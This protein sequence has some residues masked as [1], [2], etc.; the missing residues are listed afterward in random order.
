[1]VPSYQGPSSY[2]LFVKYNNYAGATAGDGNGI[3]KI[4]L[5]DPTAVASRLQY[6]A[7]ALPLIRAELGERTAM[8]GF[9]GAPWTLANFML[10][11][12]SAREFTKAK[13][14]FYS[15]QKLFGLLFEKLT[16]AVTASLQLQIDAGVDA[17]QIFDSLGGNLA[18]NIYEEASAKWIRQIISNLKGKVPVIV[19]GRGVHGSWDSLLRTGAQVLS[20]D[21]TLALGEVRGRLPENVA[22]QGNLDPVVLT[23]TPAIAAAEA[24]MILESMRGTNGHIFNL[25]HGVPPNA[26]LECI[27]SLVTT[28]QN[29]K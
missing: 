17:V 10:E 3:N 8:L 20:V 2:L 19:F 18:N 4:A 21:W 24:K 16:L 23:T 26:K 6:I 27:V 28:V 11:G 22:V 13:G 7:K 5:L 25:G 12:G 15:D 9:A 29:F 1:M 14:L